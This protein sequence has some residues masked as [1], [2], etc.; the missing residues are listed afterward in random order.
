MVVVMVGRTCRTGGLE[1]AEDVLTHSLNHL[2]ASL[3]VLASLP[4]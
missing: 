1:F 4:V 3:I 2:R